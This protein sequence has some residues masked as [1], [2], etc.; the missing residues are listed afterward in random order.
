M[1]KASDSDVWQK[2]SQ[3]LQ[4]GQEDASLMNALW[5]GIQALK[6]KRFKWVIPK[7]L[8]Q[9]DKQASNKK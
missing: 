1:S 6:P 7:A 2:R 4:E 3:R 9:L 8:P 5:K